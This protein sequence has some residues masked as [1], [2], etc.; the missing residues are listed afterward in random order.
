MRAGDIVNDGVEVLPAVDE[1]GSRV[2]FHLPQLTVR[3]TVAEAEEA[4]LLPAGPVDLPRQHVRGKRVQIADVQ[5]GDLT[6][7]VAIEREGRVV[8][9]R[10]TPRRRLDEQLRGNVEVETLPEIRPFGTAALHRL[11][12]LVQGLQHHVGP[13]FQ[14]PDGHDQPPARHAAGHGQTQSQHTLATGERRLERGRAHGAGIEQC[15]EMPAN[16]FVDARQSRCGGVGLG[17]R[18]F[19]SN[20]KTAHRGGLDEPLQS[21]KPPPQRML[22]GYLSLSGSARRHTPPTPGPASAPA[23]SPHRPCPPGATSREG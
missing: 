12:P 20:L 16:R 23:G 14:R 9:V 1:H 10:D 21:C 8:G 15:H 3:G 2:H 7:G 22:A 4:L 18:T 11:A 17:D 6:A 19:R 13:V 5:G